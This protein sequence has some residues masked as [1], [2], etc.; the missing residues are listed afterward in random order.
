LYNPYYNSYRQCTANHYP[1]TVQPGDTLN[2]IAYRLEVSV[3]RIFAANPGV[4][5]YNLRVGQMLCIPACPPNHTPKIIEPGDT[6]YQ[7][8]ITAHP[9]KQSVRLS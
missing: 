4:D 3:S 7:S 8:P 1:Y 5:P 9:H 6:L 2:S